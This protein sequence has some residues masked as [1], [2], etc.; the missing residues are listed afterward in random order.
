MGNSDT[1]SVSTPETPPRW[2]LTGHEGL[3]IQLSAP[4]KR[5]AVALARAAGLLLVCCGVEQVVGH[6]M[7]GMAV[8]QTCST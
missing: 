6:D 3:F 1:R 7:D 5:C 2:N 4:N 8:A